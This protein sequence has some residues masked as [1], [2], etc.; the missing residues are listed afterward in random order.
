MKIKPPNLKEPIIAV[1]NLPKRICEH[2][3]GEQHTKAHRSF[4]GILF[5]FIGVFIAHIEFEIVAFATAAEAFGFT[6]HA[7]GVIP[8]IE[9][10]SKTPD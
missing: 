2:V 5:M 1:L 4:V 7:I 3:V 6:I 9:M 10:L 8:F